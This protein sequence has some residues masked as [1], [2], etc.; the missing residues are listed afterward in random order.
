[1]LNLAGKGELRFSRVCVA[2]NA[3]ML[4][5]LSHSGKMSLTPSPSPKGEGRTG[6][7]A[8]LVQSYYFFF[9]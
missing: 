4:Y 2:K 8:T 3:K 9:K 5:Q 1:M 6:V 7:N